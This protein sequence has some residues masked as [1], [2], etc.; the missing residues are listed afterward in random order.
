MILT[1]FTFQCILLARLLPLY[2]MKYTRT[3]AGISHLERGHRHSLAPDLRDTYSDE[4]RA[5]VP[6]PSTTNLF[7]NIMASTAGDNPHV[8]QVRRHIGLAVSSNRRLRSLDAV[9]P[10][11]WRRIVV[12]DLHR[13]CGADDAGQG[14]PN[15]VRE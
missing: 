1:G 13:V 11:V 5:L 9:E 14:Q 3:L 4:V 12:C 15:R 10:G 6:F 7:M 8:L 2:R